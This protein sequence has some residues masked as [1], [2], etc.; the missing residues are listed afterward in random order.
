MRNCAL[1]PVEAAGKREGIVE[2][3]RETTL[4][5]A[6]RLLANGKLKLKEF[7][8]C[9]GFSL[10]QVKELLLVC[11]VLFLCRSSFASCKNAHCNFEYNGYSPKQE[12][13]RNDFIECSTVN[14][15]GEKYFHREFLPFRELNWQLYN[16]EKSLANEDKVGLSNAVARISILLH[17]YTGD[18]Q[19]PTAGKMRNLPF[20][21]RMDMLEKIEYCLARAS[22][23]KKHS[24]IRPFLDV[25]VPA[26]ILNDSQSL[27]GWHSIATFKNMLHLAIYIEDYYAVEGCYPLKLDGLGIPDRIRK[28]ACGH[29]IEYEYHANKWVLRS[30]C[31]SYD[32][33]LGF[34]EYIPMIYNQRKRLDLCF[35]PS[36]NE[37]RKILFS[38]AV[39]FKGD[40]RLAGKVIHDASMS[41]VHSVTYLNP[42]AGCGR[43]VPL[44]EQENKNY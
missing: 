12:F 21:L 30:R 2:G 34:D 23:S 10:A 3:R 16:L 11:C 41:G 24:L 38:G 22:L 35:S 28:C 39:L 18:F 13:L 14:A 5:T 1:E 26:T 25:L 43:I 15:N 20:K 37:K 36:Y 6:K 42:S 29:D 17:R 33:G 9:S 27:R 44:S 31:E 19:D 7:A 4:A 32:G 8:E 40:D